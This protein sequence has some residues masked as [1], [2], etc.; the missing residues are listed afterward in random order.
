M[1][2]GK[3]SKLRVLRQSDIGYILTDEISEVL[4]H[5]N[6]CTNQEL[7]VNDVVETFIYFD[8]K[9]RRAAT[10]QIPKITVFDCDWVEVVSVVNYGAFVNIGIRKDILLSVDDLPEDHSLWPKVGDKLYAYLLNDNDKGL[11]IKFAMKDDFL[12]IKVDAPKEVLGK[13]IKA[14][15]YNI[16]KVG[17]NVYTEE[18]YLG[19]IHENEFKEKI[20]LGEEI[21]G[22]VIDV[23]NNNEINMS[24]IPQKEIAITDD[25]E[26][27]INYLNDNDGKMPLCDKS[28]PEEIR[29]IL[30]M[31]KSAFKRAVG[32]LLKEHKVT[33]N[34]DKR[35][36]YLK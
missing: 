36:V 21:E 32:K 12:D 6:D 16:G 23:K 3:V 33:Q 31:S 15:V 26:L 9:G 10:L 29:D 34:I 28:T 35:E 14:K 30:N 8:H 22:R 27:I 25:S 20:R 2:A 11:L 17:I 13:K 4:L 5:F 7:N 18:G 24:L 19:F 1:E